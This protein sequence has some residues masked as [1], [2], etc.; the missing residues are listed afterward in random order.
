[1]DDGREGRGREG[2]RYAYQKEMRRL[3]KVEDETKLHTKLGS[4]PNYVAAYPTVDS[5]Y[6]V[7]REFIF[8][9]F[10]RL[11]NAAQSRSLTEYEKRLFVPFKQRKGRRLR[12]RLFR[13]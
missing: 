8:L 2:V 10:C 4:M 11:L 3:V 1:M 6:K 13:L 5:S 7:P 9:M 12:L